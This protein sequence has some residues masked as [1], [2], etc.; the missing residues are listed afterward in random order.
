MA[1]NMG[2]THERLVLKI[3][4]QILSENAHNIKVNHNI[5]LK[6]KDATHQ[7]D[8]YWEFLVGDKKYSV[9][10]EVKT[11]SKP[12]GQETLFQFRSVLDDLR[13]QPIGIIVSNTGYQE[14]AREYAKRRGI[15]LYELREA[16]EADWNDRIK[17][18]DIDI[19]AYTPH[20]DNIKLIQDIE[21]NIQELKR[22]N[23]PLSEASKIRVEV[24][25]NLK[26]YDENDKEITTALV[27]FNSLVP[28]GLDELPP[29]KVVYTFDKSTFINTSNPQ[30]KMK[31]K[32][33]EVTISKILV[34]KKIQIKGED[35]VSYILKNI[36]KG[37][38][39]TSSKGD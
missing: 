29:T 1:Q 5:L 9:V 15:L 11:L 39:E 28:E 33:I 8:I 20:F 7:I 6:G 18:F 14:A 21:W 16:S 19:S 23:I 32:S 12:V 13:E 22:L 30:V 24:S 17:M 37:T 38:N 4:D 25:D 35:F 26:F 34:T 31:L 27:L 10:V 3:L 2:E 36:A